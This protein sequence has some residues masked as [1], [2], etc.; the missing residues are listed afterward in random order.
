MPRILIV[1]D[2]RSARYVLRTILAPAGFDLIEAR[3]AGEARAAM[4][5]QTPDL[6]LLDMRLSPSSQRMEGVELLREFKQL[7]D[8]PVVIVSGVDDLEDIRATM[9]IGAD[10]YLMKPVQADVLLPLVQRIL[11]PEDEVTEDRATPGRRQSEQLERLVTR[12]PQMLDLRRFLLDVAPLDSTVLVRGD[13]G[14]GKELFARLLHDLGPRR[15]GPFVAVNCGAIPRNLLEGELFGSEAGAYTGSRG[16]RPGKFEQANGGTLFL[17]EVGELPMDQQAALL[18]VLQERNV[19]R[20]GGHE[21]TPVD[22]RLIAATHRTLADAVRAGEFRQDLLYR[23]DVVPI[24]IPPLSDRPNDIPLLVRHQY[25]LLTGTTLPAG[26]GVLTPLTALPWRGN[27]RELMNLVERSYILSQVG[28]LSF[29]E[30]LLREAQPGLEGLAGGPSAAAREL[31]TDTLEDD[32]VASGKNPLDGLLDR[33]RATDD[34]VTTGLLDRVER[35]LL[36]QALSHAE[37]NK[38]H[39]GRLLGIERKAVERRC[40]K[41]G[42]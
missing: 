3:D 30:T 21:P 29:V 6:V 32:P 28:D 13:T 24:H 9:A 39:A 26:D 37:G 23:L 19:V 10:D 27:V 34:D 20:L 38:T 11:E 31:D 35:A 5:R 12:D 7:G 36:E 18:R 42:L 4:L 40:R 15:D 25:Q 8:V 17:D 16:R 33:L 1:E 2:E 22:F 14:T 41:Y